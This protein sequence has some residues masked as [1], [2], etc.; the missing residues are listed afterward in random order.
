MEAARR[1]AKKVIGYDAEAS[2]VS[3][4]NELLVFARQ[5]DEETDYSVV[6][7]RQF[8]IESVVD[9]KADLLICV[10][11]LHKTRSPKWLLTKLRQ[12]MKTNGTLILEVKNGDSPYVYGETL[13]ERI[14]SWY[15]THEAMLKS[16]TMLGL[17]VEKYEKGREF[18]RMM[19][20]CRM[21][22]AAVSA[23]DHDVMI[24]L[25]DKRK[26]ERFA[27]PPPPAE[28]VPAYEQPVLHVVSPE[29]IIL[30]VP[31]EAAKAAPVVEV[32][33]PAPEPVVDAAPVEKKTVFKLKAGWLSSSKKK[34]EQHAGGNGKSNGNGHTSEER[35]PEPSP[36]E[37]LKTARSEDEVHQLEV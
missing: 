34:E 12:M 1:G 18:G 2:V 3:A 7:Y 11:T 32:S 30:E 4:A 20:G 14:N 37:P 27:E 23:E 29:K 6:E 5:Y 22:K 35:T 13:P 9:V 15:P 31:V 10:A 8:A 21:T 28:P 25:S 16:L 36:K 19:Y 33:T 24:S 26:A 17:A